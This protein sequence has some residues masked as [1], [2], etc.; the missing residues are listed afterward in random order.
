MK[1][2][3]LLLAVFALV[4]YLLGGIGT[5]VGVALIILMKG[6]DL[7][8]LGQAHSIG[9]LLVCVGLILTLLGVFV[10]RIL[11]NRG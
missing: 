1:D 3:Q 4:I 8:H 6:K 7:W 5:F 10:M 11:R 2:K 9:Y